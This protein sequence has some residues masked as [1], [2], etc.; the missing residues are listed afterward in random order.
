MCAGIVSGDDEAGFEFA[1][2]GVTGDEIAQQRLGVFGQCPKLVRVDRAEPALEFRLL[3]AKPRVDL[4][5]VAAGCREADRFGLYERRDGA[6]LGQMQRRG[7]SCEAATDDAHIGLESVLEDRMGR[8]RP[9]ADRVIALGRRRHDS[10]LNAFSSKLRIA[11]GPVLGV[12]ILTV[13]AAHAT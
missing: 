10:S 6:F 5:A 3:F 13:Q 12:P 9:G 11:L 7:Q 8:R 4:S 2:D 1:C